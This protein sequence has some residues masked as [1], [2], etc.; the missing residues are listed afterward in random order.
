MQRDLTLLIADKIRRRPDRKPNRL[1]P[2]AVEHEHRHLDVI[3]AR[4]ACDRGRRAARGWQIGYR[5]DEPKGSPARPAASGEN[6]Q[7]DAA[8]KPNACVERYRAA[9]LVVAI[10]RQMKSRRKNAWMRTAV[11]NDAERARDEGLA[12]LDSNFV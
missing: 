12:P 1:Q 9:K 5:T 7:R 11:A 2:L 6:A 8:A 10:Q 4:A 3:A